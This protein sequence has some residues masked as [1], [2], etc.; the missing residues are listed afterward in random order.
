MSKYIYDP[1]IEPFENY[2]PCMY[3]A[4]DGIIHPL[5][6]DNGVTIYQELPINIQKQVVDTISIEWP[7]FT[8]AYVRKH[9]NCATNLFYVLHK[10]DNFIG[11]VAIDRIVFLPYI[12]HLYVVKD[13]RHKGYAKYLLSI[14]EK[15]TKHL[16][17]DISRLSCKPELISFYN[18]LGYELEKEENDMYYLLKYI[19]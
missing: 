10:N 16:G 7:E 15:C 17:F 13:E 5:R 9:W 8:D 1:H 6:F 3:S 14:V 2:I 18:K 19:K 12:S 11:C 4:S